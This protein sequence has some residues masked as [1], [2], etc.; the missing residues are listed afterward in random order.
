MDIKV[1]FRRLELLGR[2]PIV[3][4]SLVYYWEEKDENTDFK[5]A[6]SFQRLKNARA[7]EWTRP[8]FELMKIDVWV[9]KAKKKLYWMCVWQVLEGLGCFL[10][11]IWVDESNHGEAIAILK[12]GSHLWYFWIN[13]FKY[14]LLFGGAFFG[15]EDWSFSPILIGSFIGKWMSSVVYMQYVTMGRLVHW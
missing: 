5:S 9:V 7:T 6:I 10:Q 4:R 3:A 12:E 15:V 2:G 8:I 1:N 14:W 13:G 11:D